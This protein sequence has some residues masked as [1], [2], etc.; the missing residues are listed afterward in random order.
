LPELLRPETSEFFASFLL[1]GFVMLSVRSRF[2]PIQRPRPSE[3]ILDA[4]VLSLIN[5]GNI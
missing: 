4:V 1:A 2:V 5:Q 3:A